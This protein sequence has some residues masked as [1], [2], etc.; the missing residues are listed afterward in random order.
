MEEVMTERKGVPGKLAGVKRPAR[1][2]GRLVGRSCKFVAETVIRLIS[3]RSLSDCEAAC[4]AETACSAFTFH[5]QGGAGVSLSGPCLLVRDCQETVWCQDCLTNTL[6]CHPP[7]PTPRP[8]L[9]EEAPRPHNVALLVAGGHSLGSLDYVKHVEMVGSDGGSCYREMTEMPVPRSRAVAGAVGAGKVLVC[10]G[11]SSRS[12]YSSSCDQLD[13]R[14]GDWAAVGERMIRGREDAG[15]SVLEGGRMVVTGGWDGESLLDSVELY[16]SHYGAWQEMGGWRLT[17]ARYQHC[18]TALGQTI[19]IAGGYPTLRLV[20]ALSLQPGERQGWTQL[21]DMTV[22]RV[23]LG[24]AVASISGTPTLFLSG[25]Q[26]GGRL[27]SSVES[28]ALA[29]REAGTWSSLADLPLPR[30]HHIMIALASPPRLLVVGGD[31]NTYTHL[32]HL[33]QLVS[34]HLEDDGGGWNITGHLLSPRTVMAAAVVDEK[35]CRAR[36]WEDQNLFK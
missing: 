24:C 33:S 29:G 21:Q 22:G 34:L 1:G 17:R 36:D 10:G 27:L 20:Q 30:R 7:L 32:S 19:I 13:L 26:S 23:A 8:L 25:G 6:N 5:P 31:T 16:H 4:R 15:V 2:C 28:L 11:R 35:Y 9:T 14:T 3:T 12:K 18:A